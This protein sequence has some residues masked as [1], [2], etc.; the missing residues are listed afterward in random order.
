MKKGTKKKQQLPKKGLETL[1]GH[2]K[3]RKILI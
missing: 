2:Q 3:A 1:A